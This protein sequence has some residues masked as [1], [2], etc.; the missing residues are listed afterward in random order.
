MRDEKLTTVLEW[1]KQLQ[2][3]TR[4]PP[5]RPPA[6]PQPPRRAVNG[7]APLAGGPARAR[8]VGRGYA[9]NKTTFDART[10]AALICG[11]RCATLGLAGAGAMG[12]AGAEVEWRTLPLGMRTE[13]SR[14]SVVSWSIHS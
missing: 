8:C 12:G 3:T 13:G 10:K 7:P 4:Q 14:A 11:R 6:A 5:P 1:T 2:E 9:A